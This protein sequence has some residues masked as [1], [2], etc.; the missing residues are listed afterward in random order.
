MKFDGLGDEQKA[1]LTGARTPEEVLE[2]SDGELAQIAGGTP[3]W[4]IPKCPKCGGPLREE[5][6]YVVCDKCGYKKIKANK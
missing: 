3:S 6:A 4:M 5:G 2:L 1:K